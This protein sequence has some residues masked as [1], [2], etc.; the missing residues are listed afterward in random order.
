MAG[1]SGSEVRDIPLEKI[2]TSKF[3]VRKDLSAGT[4][5]SSLEDLA[6][7]IRQKGLLSPVTVRPV[8]DRYELIAGQRR[9][10]AC[11]RLGLP[12]IR[13]VVRFGTSDTDS[14]EISLIENVHRAEMHP[15]DKARALHDLL[16][17]YSGDMSRVAKET[18]ISQQT[19]R[20][21]LAI[22]SLPPEIQAKLSTAEGPARVGALAVLAQT[23]S[24]PEAMVQAYDQISG[25]TQPVQMAILNASGGDV[26]KVSG[27]VDQALAGAFDVH[28]CAGVGGLLVCDELSR[29][30]K[31]TSRPKCGSSHEFA[32]PMLLGIIMVQA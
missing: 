10:L 12:T 9:L 11:Q 22:S 8:G 21:Y 28:T 32:R 14:L 18:G 13:A 6:D 26:G 4:E 2:D 19:V 24:D 23:F 31:R 29:L 1:D 3:N 25:F 15:L 27:L 20:K 16:G 17:A 5:E 7:S 30:P